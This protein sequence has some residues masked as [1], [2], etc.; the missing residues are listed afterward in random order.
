M[1][2]D[3]KSNNGSGG[4][5]RSDPA[6]DQSDDRPDPNVVSIENMRRMVQQQQAAAAK[7]AKKAA[8]AEAGPM[9]NLPPITK[10]LIG[11]LLLIHAY[12][13]FGM[14][15]MARY[16]LF[17]HVGFIPGYYSGYVDSYGLEPFYGP[18]VYMFFH[19]SWLHIALNGVMLLAFGAAIERWLG[20]RRLLALFYL[21]SLAALIPHYL[22]YMDSAN[23]VIG[24][25]GG[26]SGL[27]AAAIIMMQQRM[28]IALGR[29][30]IW[31]F[32]ALW[33]VISF[34]FGLTGGPDGSTIA[35]AA[36][37]GGFIAGLLLL[38]PVR[39]FIP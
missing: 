33:V 6:A 29:Y 15:N 39:R 26:L 18:F 27:F 14:D 31:P 21:S 3:D 17:Q 11:F 36:H 22:L 28:G 35:W 8:Q 34:V 19:G 37:I 30:G 1:M 7:T 13:S 24:A 23:P 2:D 12:I 20:W 25:S 38:G 10:Y 9:I 4:N 16:E 5:G 32:I